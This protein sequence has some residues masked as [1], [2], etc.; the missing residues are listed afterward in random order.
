VDGIDNPAPED[1]DAIKAD[2]NLALLPRA[3]GNIFYI[4]FNN[5]I[6]PFDDP[7][8]RLAFS[9]AIDRQTIVDKYYPKGSTVAQNFVPDFFAPGFSKDI[10]WNTYDPAAAKKMLTD[11]GFDFNQEIQLAFRNVVRSYLPT[12]DKVAQEIQ[13]QLKANLGITVKLEEMESTA[14]IDATAAGEKGFYLLGWGMDYPDATNFYDYHFANASNQQFGDL[15]PDL[16]KE[17]NA[18]AVLSDPAARQAI[19]DKVNELIKVLVPMIP[20][21]HGGSATAYKA[22]VEGAHSS[23]LGNEVFAVMNNGTDQMVWMQSGEPAALWC[24]DETDGETLRAC[25]QLAD[26]LLAF[27]V[28]GAEVEPGLAEKYEA[29]KDLTEW[30]FTLRQGVKFQNGAMLDANDVV[31][32]YESFWNA[33]SPNHKGRTGTFEY[34]TTFFGAFLNVAK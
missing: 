9:M 33:A 29:N 31:A 7:K 10:T 26:A 5:K 27:K 20:V 2:A 25:E 13:G 3:A 30:T 11:A 12:P 18:A 15:Y 4:G 6:K 34:F 24:S 14:F 32:T 17:I 8:V 28:G 21:A 19:Y 22:N 16:V 23:P 1:F